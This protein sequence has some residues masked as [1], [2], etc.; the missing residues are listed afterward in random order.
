MSGYKGT[1]MVVSHDRYFLDRIANRIFEVENHKV[2]TYEGNYTRSLSQ[3]ALRRETQQRAYDNQQREIA[4]QE[5]MIRKMKQ[6]GTEHLAKRA[7]SREKRLD[8]LERVERPEALKGR[9]KI[10]F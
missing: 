7:A 8:M 9:M 4:R 3:K 1:I 5:E 2:Y 10:S 6:H